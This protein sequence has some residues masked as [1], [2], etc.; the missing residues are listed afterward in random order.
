MI[1]NSSV[2]S[3][4]KENFRLSQPNPSLFDGILFLP[5]VVNIFIMNV[6]GVVNGQE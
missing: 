6:P 3:E 5:G 1:G 2:V 4:W